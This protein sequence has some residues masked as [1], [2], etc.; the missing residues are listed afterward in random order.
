MGMIVIVTLE[1]LVHGYLKYLCAKKLDH[2]C[3]ETLSFL[4]LSLVP[5]AASG[6][7]SSIAKKTGVMDIPSCLIFP[8]LSGTH[9]FKH[10]CHYLQ[11]IFNIDFCLFSL[12]RP[13]SSNTLCEENLVWFM[14][15]V[16][17]GHVEYGGNKQNKKFPKLIFFLGHFKFRLSVSPVLSFKPVSKT[18]V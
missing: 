10:L 12:K 13:C 5:A 16:A 2:R 18:T 7:S 8:K 6:T 4:D 3:Q 9:N 14:L 1:N 15:Q 17:E 11:Q